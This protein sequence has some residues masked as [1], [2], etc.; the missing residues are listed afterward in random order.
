MVAQTTTGWWHQQSGRHRRHTKEPSASS[1]E[2]RSNTTSQFA[3]WPPRDTLRISHATKNSKLLFASLTWKLLARQ[4]RR[5]SPDPKP[6]TAS[7]SEQHHATTTRASKTT[8]FPPLFRHVLCFPWWVINAADAAVLP[9]L[10][11]GR[12]HSLS[13]CCWLLFFLSLSSWTN[14]KVL[15]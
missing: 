13:S 4:L 1:E 2:A 6:P 10:L 5:V 9:C 14:N 15:P 8:I 3:S 7:T 12:H 11:T